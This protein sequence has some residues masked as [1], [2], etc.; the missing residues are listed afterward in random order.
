LPEY[1]H[2]LNLPALTVCWG[3][4]RDV[5]YVAQ[6]GDIKEH[7]R[8]QGFDE[9]TLSQAWKAIS[10]GLKNSLNTIGVAPVDWK[11]AA[12]YN[13]SIGTSPRYSR[14][15]QIHENNIGTGKNDNKRI[16]INSAMDPHE[17][18][19]KLTEALSR[20]IAAI[21]GV[22]L[23]KF[24]PQQPIS[25]LGFDSLMA[26]ELVVRI[27]KIVNIKL[28]KITLLRAGLNII[29]LVDIVEKEILQT[30]VTV[31]DR[32]SNEKR[33]GENAQISVNVN[34]LSDKEVEELLSTILSEGGV[35]DE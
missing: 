12:R 23:S 18:R 31:Q 13:Y 1:R 29:E 33:N 4:I 11:T 22:P 27:E 21:L 30:K 28:P 15:V 19:Q 14:L 34:E 25:N 6:R 9:V 10:L 7:F 16:I 17:R 20:E 35:K 2:S 3:P 26:V 32:S 24:D 8:R 5:G